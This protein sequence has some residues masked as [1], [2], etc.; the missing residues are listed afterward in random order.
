MSALARSLNAHILGDCR[1]SF[2]TICLCV[3]GIVCVA[4]PL[5]ISQ[6]VIAIVAAIAYAVLQE[7]RR[8]SSTV[9]G[10]GGSFKRASAGFCQENQQAIHPHPRRGGT[11]Y[12]SSSDLVHPTNSPHVSELAEFSSGRAS[13]IG[14]QMRRSTFDREATRSTSRS[15]GSIR[16]FP[17]ESSGA[18]QVAAAA[19]GRAP[20][21]E[22]LRRSTFDKETPA[23]GGGRKSVLGDQLRHSTF[24]KEVLDLVAMISPSPASDRMVKEL[25][26]SV[27]QTIRAALPEAQVVGFSSGDL[28]GS[29]TLGMGDPE[30]D[31][32]VSVNPDALPGQLKGRLARS[33]VASQ[34]NLDAR[35][36]QKSAIRACTDRLVSAGGFKFRRS[37]FRGQEPKVTLLAPASFTAPFA[38]IRS[39]AQKVETDAACDKVAPVPIDLSV[40]TMTSI[41]SDAVL[42]ACSRLDS[43]AKAL[44]VL[45]R[46]WA[47][48]RGI[49]L[50]AKGHLSPYS[51]SLL[52]AFFLQVTRE[53]D[54]PMLPCLEG[55]Q[56]GN[57]GAVIQPAP[58]HKGLPEWTPKAG[59]SKSRSAVVEKSV[60]TLFAEFVNFY[61]NDFNW[62]SEAVSIRA[63]RRAA[64]DMAMQLHIIVSSTGVPEQV[65]PHIQDPFEP[66][67]NLGTSVTVEGFERMREELS[68]AAQILGRESPEPSLEEI[69]TPWV[70][71]NS[72]L[73]AD[74]DMES[75]SASHRVSEASLPS[76]DDG[77][78]LQFN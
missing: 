13:S 77:R 66:R 47:R 70:V 53:G 46:R 71:P 44:V 4:L 68:R 22:Q 34:G 57:S 30:V 75:I 27:Q 21:R 42:Q 20:I 40:N 8:S 62:R 18:Q 59:G 56:K 14:T 19:G 67:C 2:S 25:A 72:G 39:A 36:V 64:P 69:I 15:G 28:A 51:W 76:M 9:R 35:K 32:V 7:F 1:Y 45:V 58:P 5:S 48:D 33:G 23:V 6:L 55:V 38:P 49:C 37:A 52:T 12:E 11:S 41:H 29:C 3:V 61:H 63:G 24:N 31:I 78:F 17:Y 50:A 65:G 10:K 26:R 73:D 43:R 16:N 60:G 74:G 54:T